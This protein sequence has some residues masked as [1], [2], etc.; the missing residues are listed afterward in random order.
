[1]TLS[2]S[3]SN[4]KEDLKNEY[5]KQYRHNNLYSTNFE[6]DKLDNSMNLNAEDYKI[7]PRSYSPQDQVYINLISQSRGKK[8]FSM[9]PGQTNLNYSK[10]SSVDIIDHDKGV[11]T[12]QSKNILPVISRS[13]ESVDY[14]KSINF[15]NPYIK[16][17]S[18]MADVKQCT[19]LPNLI[20]NTRRRL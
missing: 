12:I 11:F 5:I 13:L 14:P 8:Q 2:S 1:M 4:L 20:N 18:Q 17:I 7:V 16:K 6:S 3:H 19:I 15:R 10:H 9:I